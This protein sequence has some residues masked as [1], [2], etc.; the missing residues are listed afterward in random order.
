MVK[1]PFPPGCILFYQLSPAMEEETTLFHTC[2]YT[3]HSKCTSH[4]KSPHCLYIRAGLNPHL[5]HEGLLFIN[6][7]NYYVNVDCLKLC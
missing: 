6:V 5:Q 7:H 4:I 3:A 1:Y 2:N